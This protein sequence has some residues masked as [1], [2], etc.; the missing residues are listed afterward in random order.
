M[1]P[2]RYSERNLLSLLRYALER[3]GVSEDNLGV[4]KSGDYWIGKRASWYPENTRSL[5]KWDDGR[6]VIGVNEERGRGFRFRAVH[7]DLGEAVVD[8][9]W[10]I[11]G[12]RGIWYQDEI[13]NY[14]DWERV[15]CRVRTVVAAALEQAGISSDSYLI[16]AV[17]DERSA[18]GDRFCLLSCDTESWV[19]LRVKDG[20]SSREAE[21]YDSLRAS[22]YFYWKFCRN[23]T[24]FT[25]LDEWRRAAGLTL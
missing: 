20:V 6:W 16:G 19:T 15:K 12:V 17:G 5:V 9:Y 18:G 22:E 2:M 25:Y 13:Y 21:H 23:D 1:E 14:R 24:P 4:H 3:N 11:C 8:Y 10:K 7:T